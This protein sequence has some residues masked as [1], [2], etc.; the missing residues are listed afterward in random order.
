[1]VI[2]FALAVI[3][4]IISGIYR[5]A[6]WRIIPCCNKQNSPVI[7]TQIL[8]YLIIFALTFA[9]SLLF[10]SEPSRSSNMILYYRAFNRLFHAPYAASLESVILFIIMVAS[11]S[12][13]L[14]NDIPWFL[15]L[16]IIHIALHRLMIF[17]NKCLFI[18]VSIN[19]AYKNTKQRFGS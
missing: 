11:N 6:L 17:F 18:A 1:M 12:N 16:F 4:Y 14:K 15:V 3:N 10:A 13:P 8:R 19:T 7:I 2:A 9:Y 5:K